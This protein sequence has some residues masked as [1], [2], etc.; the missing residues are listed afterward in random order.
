MRVRAALAA[1]LLGV[2]LLP[3]ARGADLLGVVQDALEHD[4]ALAGMRA[5]ERA[6]REA[7]PK[8]RAALLPQVSG[9]WGR[10]YNREAVDGYPALHYWQNGWTVTLEQPLFDWARWMSLQQADHIAARGTLL[11]E[12]ARVASIL[13]AADAYFEV[14]SAA[15]EATRADEYRRALDAHLT[16]LKRAHAAGVVTIVDLRDAEA[17]MAEAQLQQLDAQGRHQR[18]RAALE[19]LT[20]QPTD[21]LA[22]LPQ[23][24]IVPTLAPADVDAWVTQAAARSY[25]VQIRE[26]ELEIAKYETEKA[27][28]GH[29]PSVGV[30]VSHT[31]AGVAAGYARP[32][33]TTTAMIGVTI[34][35]FSGG[36]TTAK[37]REASALADKAR[38]DLEGATRVAAADAR[39]AWLRVESGKQRVAALQ[40]L[41][42][43]AA[44]AA[45]AT[46]TGFGVGSRTANDVLR[47]LGAEYAARRD[48]I[49][50]RYAT[51]LALLKLLAC[52]AILDVDEVARING[53]LFTAGPA[54]PVRGAQTGA[55]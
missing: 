7:V 15:D 42:Q 32:T 25:V 29:Y 26:V 38:D 8:A 43:R 28:A 10:V 51:V 3:C 5:G 16:M 31:P 46:R 27:R 13:K 48:L 4:A 30:Q 49:Q 6:A 36:E 1:W 44:D 40:Q 54:L 53:V 9:G 50:A 11:A 37:V 24:G 33:T 55:Q 2:A 20:G 35:L 52:A 21:T 17:A 45:A 22:R 12:D 19:A 34:P 18:A 47:T 39:D 41:V 23:N 14:L